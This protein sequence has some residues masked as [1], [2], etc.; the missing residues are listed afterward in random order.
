MPFSAPILKKSAYL[1]RQADPTQNYTQ[2]MTPAY[3]T[4]RNELT[5]I[6]LEI[7][8]HLIKILLRRSIHGQQIHH[9]II[10]GLI[11]LFKL[12]FIHLVKGNALYGLLPTSAANVPDRLKEASRDLHRPPES[13]L[14]EALPVGSTAKEQ[15]LPFCEQ[16]PSRIEHT[17]VLTMEQDISGK[18]DICL[19]VLADHKLL[20]LVIVLIIQRDKA[21]ICIL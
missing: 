19:I 16:R 8:Y 10:H 2:V 6:L 9:S 17:K 14:S 7:I 4:N 5:V 1:H 11:Q 13:L 20:L 18:L 12:P 15:T 21:M 3:L